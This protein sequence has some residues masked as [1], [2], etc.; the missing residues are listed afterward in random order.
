[1]AKFH[2]DLEYKFDSIKM[3]FKLE[4]DHR[5]PRTK[6][7]MWAQKHLY[8]I[9]HIFHK[10]VIALRLEALLSGNTKEYERLLA[11]PTE[12]SFTAYVEE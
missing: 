4:T 5:I 1:M 3:Q 6:F 9:E 2:A 7:S 8:R 11:I 12:G 10:R